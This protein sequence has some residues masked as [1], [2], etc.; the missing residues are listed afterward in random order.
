MFC[1]K[2]GD[3]IEPNEKFCNKCGNPLNV[4]QSN[5]ENQ[6]ITNP[7]QNSLNNSNI[8]YNTQNIN[9][10]YQGFQPINAQNSYQENYMNTPSNKDNKKMMFIGVGIGI[11]VFLLL[12]LITH[13]MG[14]SSE[15]YYFD[16][17]PNEQNNEIIQT[18]GSSTKK[19]KYGT[20]IIYDNTYSGVKINKDTDAFA[21]IV[22]DSVNQKNKC[23]SDIK[24]VEDEII[25]NYGIT[26][27]NL[28]EMDVDFARELGNVF[29][30]IYD[31][32]PSVRGYITNLTLVN[33]SMTDNY[34]AAFMPVFNFATSDTASTYPWVIKTQVL[35]NT[36]YF[37]NKERL[38]ASV[39]DGSSTGHFPKNSTIYSP[40][41][42]E[43]GHYLSFLAMMK[44]YKLDS[45]LLVDSNNVSTFYS[46]Y[47]DFG[48]GN[49]SLTMIKE[50]FQKYKK[51]TNSTLNLDEWRGTISNYALAKDNSGEY[52]YDETIA[53]S[54][55]DVYLNGDNAS[56]ASKYVVSVLKEK[57]GS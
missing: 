30:K 57:L 38:E 40:V 35:L 3:P 5:F 22:K 27:V 56:D 33:V 36:S 28:C 45:I 9:N 54:F 52:I 39:T 4:P 11:G 12:F 20:V 44:N 37:L 1:N 18:T 48:K 7:A 16:T 15:R 42:H 17:N 47:D 55:H 2:C 29:K 43:L 14:N 19:G 8:G 13:F 53:E 21:L 26:A 23:P 24:K 34:I 41:A 51:D 50:A 25:K 10:N 46:L 6:N 32:Y 31:E 49:Y